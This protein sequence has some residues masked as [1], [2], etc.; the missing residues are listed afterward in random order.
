MS[1]SDGL[2]LFGVVFTVIVAVFTASYWVITKIAELSSEM[3]LAQQSSTLHMQRSD[4]QYR[5]VTMKVTALQ[6]DVAGLRS[7]LGDVTSAVGEL[8]GTLNGHEKH[9]DLLLRNAGVVPAASPLHDETSRHARS[10]RS[11]P[12]LTP[13]PNAVEK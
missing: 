9:I 1:F 4:E 13:H 6:K 10:R 8:S 5:S 12:T 7:E 11:I 3:K 2:S